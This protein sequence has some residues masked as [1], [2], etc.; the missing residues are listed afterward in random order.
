VAGLSSADLWDWT[1]NGLK[2]QPTRVSPNGEWLEFMSGRALTAYD[3]R[4]VTT[5]TPVAEVYLYSAASGRVLCASCDPTGARPH[6]VEYNKLLHGLVGG[7]DPSWITDELVAASVP[8]TSAVN[9]GIAGYQDRYLSDT[10]RLFFNAT[11]GL[12]SHDSNGT[13]D[14][15]E[16]EPAGV[17][18]CNES[19]PTFDRQSGGCVDLVSSGTSG[20]ESVFLDASETG[21]DVFF[22]TSA[23]LSYR[24]TDA[25]GDVYDAHVGGVEA[26]PVRPVECQGDACQ[27]FVEAPNDPTPGSLTFRG[28]GNVL[29]QPTGQTA[30]RSTHPAHKKC[31]GARKVVHGKC[32]KKKAK[33]KIKVK[34]ANHRRTKR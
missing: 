24:D 22:L 29:A 27:G 17:G 14:V 33:R 18:S 5:G 32:V 11:D 4:S 2:F 9:D 34:K 31:V 8:A 15:Y 13:V 28:P 20:L 10:G 25:A 21:D 3:S 6:G 19:T 23:R 1:K 16:Y 7:Y 12:V 26:E 30:L